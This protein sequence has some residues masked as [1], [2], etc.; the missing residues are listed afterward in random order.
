MRDRESEKIMNYKR[1]D[2]EKSL[3][4]LLLYFMIVD[5][6]LGANNMSGVLCHKIIVDGNVHVFLW[7]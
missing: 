5:Y 7:H 2:K 6:I 4:L 1:S 3:L